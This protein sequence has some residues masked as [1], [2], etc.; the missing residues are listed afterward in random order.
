MCRGVKERKFNVKSIS[1]VAARVSTAQDIFSNQESSNN[2]YNF[3]LHKIKYENVINNFNIEISNLL[4]FLNLD[5]EYAVKNYHVTAKNRD[6]INTPSYHQVIKPIYK[7]SLDRYK[8]FPETEKL[9]PLI[10]KWV[11]QFGY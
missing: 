9:L 3:S 8:N 6:K 10:K 1:N 11:D 2:T 5:F 4:L 7:D